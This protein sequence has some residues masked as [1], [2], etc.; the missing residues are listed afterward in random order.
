MRDMENRARWMG[1]T[2][3]GRAV[4][5]PIISSAPCSVSSLTAL[6]PLYRSRG[7]AFL[8][9][10]FLYSCHSEALAV[11]YDILETTGLDNA[12]HL[13]LGESRTGSI[14][15][16]Q[17]IEH[18]IDL[19][20]G[21]YLLTVDQRGLDLTIGIVEPIALAVNS[22]APRE[23][24][25]TAL[26][27]PTS[28]NNRY[29]IVIN[30]DEYTGAVGAYS[31]SITK[32]VD[33]VAISGYRYMTDAAVANHKGGGENWQKSLEL[34]VEALSIWRQLD[35]T[36][37]QA[38][39][40]LYIAYLHNWQFLSWNAAVEAAAEAASLYA[41]NG[42][43]ILYANA[44]RLHA[45]SL[46]E[47]ALASK[48]SDSSQSRLDEAQSMFDEALHLLGTAL[49]AQAKL[50]NHYDEAQTLNNIG[51]TYYYMDDWSQARL[52]YE[53]AVI[54]FRNLNESS[55]ELNPLANLS[56][57]DFE[58][59]NLVRAVDSFTRLLELIPAKQEPGWRADTLD[60][61]GAALLS[62]GQVDGALKNYSAAL[63]L[64]EKL[65]SVKGQGRSLTGIGSTYYSVGEIEL[66]RQFF[67]RA[68]PIRQQANDG[69]G[70]ISVL[71]YLGDIHRHLQQ[72]DLA[73]YRHNQALELTKSPMAEAKI[74]ILKARDWIDAGAYTEAIEL[75]D[76]VN[77]AVEDTRASAVAADA[78]YELGRAL[79]RSGDS[80]LAQTN[81]KTAQTLYKDIGL[82]DGQARSLLEL[83]RISK[84]VNLDVAI[85]FAY[86]AIAYIEQ[87]RS[88]VANPELRAVYLSTR[89]DYYEF[90]IDTLMQ[91]RDE[92]V[93][94]ASSDEYLLR[95]LAVAERA[96]ARATADLMSEAAVN[97]RQGVDPTL[98]ARQYDLYSQLVEKQYQRDQLLQQ[99]AGQAKVDIAVIELQDIHA[100]LDVLEI[101][102]RQTNPK[103]ATLSDPNVL[104]THQIQT[105]LDDDTV[106]L[107]YWL[108]EV[109][110]YLWIVSRTDVQGI[111]IADRNAI[112]KLARSA[113]ESLSKAEFDRPASIS[114]QAALTSLS[115]MIMV[116]ATAA[117]HDKTR[118]IVAA[119]G[120]LQ[121]IPFSLL[122]FDRK[123]A[124]I[125]THE[126]VVV[127]SMTVLA[128]QRQ[129]FTDRTA[130]SKTLAVF[131][132]PVFE[133]SDLRLAH[134]QTDKVPSNAQ[135]PEHIL[136]SFDTKTTLSRLPFS[137]KEVKHI[138]GLVPDSERLVATGFA[139]NKDEI[140]GGVLA[141]YKYIHFATH[142][143]INSTHP[144]LSTLVFS[145]L[146]E[147]GESLNGDLR[148]HDIYNL[149]LSADLVVLSACETG[150]GREI[151]G[152]GLIGLTQGFMYAG[153]SSVIASLWRVSDRATEELMT[154]FYKNLLED[155]QTPAAALRSAQMDLA[156]QR[157]WRN[158]YYWSGFV[159]HGDWL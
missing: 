154:Q 143:L 109:E 9:G 121:Y 103:V 156:K 40:L 159:L 157:R 112:E 59:G 53:K 57:I 15:A 149:E 94:E 76:A 2:L 25:E 111:R 47:A 144:S 107:Q 96:R 104:D 43:T 146:D 99:E 89:R 84:A 88:R 5:G 140:I 24:R 110:S 66:A 28:G 145:L 60:N 90:L 73:L 71:H 119:D 62:L 81:L 115:E 134:S 31:I 70:Q 13:M 152:E 118:V 17:K 20:P 116:P 6:T 75:L 63:A 98:Q 129:A 117:I 80:A 39:T 49:E 106:V 120:A 30:S 54:K 65:D 56:V 87:L 100:A 22:P 93:G 83:A 150:L 114:R 108:G 141:N 131:G 86:R 92:A 44:T 132:D 82:R 46:I 19:A 138:A 105:L 148:L 151:R 18:T 72:F 128:A 12:S 27:L 74:K 3:R 16:D 67:A 11:G 142:G 69:R 32:L 1:S 102:L 125:D 51:L 33:A 45:S 85:E 64:H 14:S 48:S 127:P 42:E 10:L 123:K 26:L 8:L 158:P 52:Y 135:T 7:F 113:Y 78:A 147:S 37:E 68:L 130:A 79:A 133:R 122:S 38:R 29:T 139:A 91:A 126:V 136:G 55:A 50:N 41:E 23:D 101:E 58:R 155:G 4:P 77:V 124:L 95:A 153:A 61:L 36:T 21:A 35:N 137:A 97:L 34:Y